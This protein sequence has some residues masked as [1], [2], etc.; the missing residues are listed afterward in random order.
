MSDKG[1]CLARKYLKSLVASL[2]KISLLE[3]MRLKRR[4]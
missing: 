3:Q 1:H 2:R 4:N